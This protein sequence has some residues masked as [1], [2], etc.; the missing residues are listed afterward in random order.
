MGEI[1]DMM[2]DGTMCQGC[3]EFLHD[4]EDGPGYPGWCESCR[5]RDEA[6]TPTIRAIKPAKGVP[7]EFCEG[8]PIAKKLVKTLEG[9]AKSGT[10]DGPLTPAK[11]Q[12]MYAGVPWDLASSQYDRLAK[13]GLVERRSP[14]NPAHKDHAVIT[15]AGL[16]FLAKRK[17]K[18]NG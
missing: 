10:E 16:N 18:K 4:G 12:S 5:P 13:R 3:G 9:L 8:Q 7:H 14:H 1:A 17:K 6:R 11:G 2:L 15:K